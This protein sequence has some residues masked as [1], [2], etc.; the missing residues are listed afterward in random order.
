[1]FHCI[2]KYRNG[3]VKFQQDDERRDSIPEEPE[4]QQTNHIDRSNT[5]MVPLAEER[6]QFGRSQS[7]VEQ[8][9]DNQTV[10]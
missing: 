4:N 10:K 9:E 8:I 2:Y 3:F 5:L 7:L 6:R 1:M